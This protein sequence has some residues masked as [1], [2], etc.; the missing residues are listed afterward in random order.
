M[1]SQDDHLTYNFILQLE[2]LNAF[3]LNTHRYEHCFN[4]NRYL[5][6]LLNIM[7]AGTL[8]LTCVY[9]RTYNNVCVY[10]MYAFANHIRSTLL[11]RKR[12]SYT[13]LY[14]PCLFFLNNA[15]SQYYLSLNLSL[16]L[17]ISIVIPVPS[18][19]CR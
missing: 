10:Y 2:I 14:S 15:I 9:V 6:T 17:G 8:Y 19:G 3:L 5:A 12:L 1:I 18:V 16:D 7:S 13:N 11:L 4:C